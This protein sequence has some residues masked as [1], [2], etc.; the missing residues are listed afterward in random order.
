[1]YEYMLKMF[2][3]FV[4][5][6][7]I[8]LIAGMIVFWARPSHARDYGEWLNGCEQYRATVI[9]VLE[10]EGVHSDYYYLM[11]AESRCTEN[12]ISGKGARGFWQLMPLTAKHYG[13][14][15]PHELE[16][17]T[18]AAARYIKHLQEVFPTF[19]QVIAAYN[20]GGHNFKRLGISRQAHGLVERVNSIRRH[21]N[22]D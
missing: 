12:A 8:L 17:A 3:R 20:M 1:M 10:A 7:F 14:E 21:D 19:N 6:V 16:C 9:D 2:E 5:V 13:C 11:V 22:D 18:R 15:Q 4:F